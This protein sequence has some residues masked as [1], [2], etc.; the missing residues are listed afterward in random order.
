[1]DA[2]TKIFLV[3]DDPTMAVV[4]ESILGDRYEVSAFENAEHCL[5]RL[6]AGLPAV[7]LLDVQ[8]PGMDGYELCRRI[9]AAPEAAHVPVIFLSANDSVEAVLAGYDAGAEDYLVKPFGKVPL[10]RKIENLL[11]IHA[12]RQ[13]LRRRAEDSEQL[14]NVVMA[15]LNEYAALIRFLR[16]LNECRDYQGVVEAVLAVLD[17]YQLEGAVQVRMRSLERTFGRAG[18]NWPMELAVI[19]HV[20]TL[21][22]IFEFRSRSVY[23]FDRVSILVTSMPLADPDRCGRIRDDLAIVAESADAK[24]AAI[25]ETADK[26]RLRSEISELL[27]DLG[28]HVDRYGRSYQHARYQS[29]EHTVRLLD[30]LLVATAH[31]GMSGEQEDAILDLVKR[32]SEQLADLY[33]FAGETSTDLA[34]LRTRLEALIS[35]TADAVMR[36]ACGEPASAGSLVPA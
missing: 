18:E 5:E 2:A 17:S 35:T 32:R 20:R 28:D 21:G 31:L 16:A 25:Q 15:S 1:M 33:D 29:S 8:M 14:A 23:N 12:D 34:D 26:L 30:E 19:N 6:P 4:V 22:R 9:K 27:R 11:R 3:D 36:G 7:F 24:L 13:A 10:D